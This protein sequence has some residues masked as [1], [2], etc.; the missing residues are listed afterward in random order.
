MDVKTA[1]HQLYINTDIR[2]VCVCVAVCDNVVVT[3]VVAAQR[4]EAVEIN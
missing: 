1:L 2:T 3:V 4:R